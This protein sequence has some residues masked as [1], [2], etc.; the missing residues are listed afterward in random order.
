MAEV[1]RFQPTGPT[2]PQAFVDKLGIF[3]LAENSFAKYVENP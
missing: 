1:H 3:L 2:Y